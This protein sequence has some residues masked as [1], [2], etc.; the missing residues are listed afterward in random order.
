[1]KSPEIWEKSEGNCYICGLPMLIGSE[2]EY[3][4]YTIEHWKPKSRKGTNKQE[5]KFGAHYLC[6]NKKGNRTEAEIDGKF[7]ES[8]RWEIKR[9]LKGWGIE[10]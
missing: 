1:M 8:C 10:P 6:N 3:L 9:L 7:I 4:N 5:N 2:C